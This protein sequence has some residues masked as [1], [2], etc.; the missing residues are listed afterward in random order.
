MSRPNVLVLYATRHGQARKIAERLAAG[1]NGKG[2]NVDVLN[3]K[4]LA[5]A[6]DPDHYG[7]AI[8][9]ASIHVGK[10]EP[11]MVSF[12]RHHRELLE[13]IPSAFVSVS[14]AEATLEGK[15]RTAAAREQAA[16]TVRKALDTFITQTGWRPK[17]VRPVA[18]ALL[19]REYNFFIRFIMKM[20]ARSTGADTDTSKNYEYTDWAAV[21]RF[22]AEFNF[23][24]TGASARIA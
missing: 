10:H 2:A 8:L 17:V 3:A 16:V 21:D 20:I 14:M 15:D 7:A 18:G 6:F 13:S 12:A 5:P 19:Y 22:A 23:T 1:L 11:E 24:N 4:Q 9:V